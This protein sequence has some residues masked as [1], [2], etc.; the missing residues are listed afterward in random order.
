VF[1]SLFDFGD[2]S[3]LYR[4]PGREAPGWHWPLSVHLPCANRRNVSLKGWFKS[5]VLFYLLNL[6]L[7]LLNV[8]LKDFFGFWLHQKFPSFIFRD[9][10]ATFVLINLRLEAVL[11]FKLLLSLVENFLA[12][13]S[14]GWT[15]PLYVLL[16][17]MRHSRIVKLRLHMIVQVLA[18]VSFLGRLL[19]FCRLL[20]LWERIITLLIFK[21]SLSRIWA[22][23]LPEIVAFLLVDV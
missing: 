10:R 15:T 7:C 17:V 4:F 20:R 14:G 19:S 12:F 5:T 23:R 2:Q 21:S 1:L 6:F 8:S 3:I 13:V 11:L 18:R 22:R 16:N 9:L